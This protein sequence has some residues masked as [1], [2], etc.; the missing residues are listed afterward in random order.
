MSVTL[1]NDVSQQIVEKWAPVFTDELKESSLLASLVSREYQGDIGPNGNSVKVSQIDRPSAERKTI[2]TAG[3]DSFAS[4]KVTTKQVEVVADQRITASYEFEDLV[5]LQSQIGAQDSKMRAGLVEALEIDLNSYLY[6]LVAPIGAAPDHTITGVTDFNAGQI[7]N[8]NKLAQQ[9]KWRKDKGYWLMV[10]PSYYKDL[11]DATTLTSQDQVPDRP[12][13]AGQFATQ[14]FGFNILADNSAGLASLSASGE[15]AALAFQPDFMYLVMQ[16][17][18][19]F[20]LSSKHAMKQ[21]GFVLSVDMIVGA[22]LGIDGDRK[23]ITVI[24]S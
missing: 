18:P 9:A 8:L 1:L 20:Q 6:S 15:D 2:G 10:D 12:V 21:H 3:S 19:R 16:R 4:A 24:N 5:E 7:S 14:R 13:V 17:E 22:K 11:L 23:H